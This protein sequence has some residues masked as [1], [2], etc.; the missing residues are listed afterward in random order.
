MAELPKSKTADRRTLILMRHAKSSWADS[1]MDDH[2]R[3]LNDRGRSSAPLI[4]N[5]LAEQNLIP[6]LILCSTAIRTLQTAAI[7][8]NTWTS[9]NNADVIQ[10]DCGDLYLATPNGILECLAKR[11]PTDP[12]PGKVLLLGHNPGSELLASILCGQIVTMPTAACVVFDLDTRNQS[13]WK[14]DLSAGGISKTK[15]VSPKGL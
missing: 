13:S 6:E 10:V 2:S 9:M 15:Q 7:L 1:G 12:M 8:R 3:P 14:I 4:A 5:W 11:C